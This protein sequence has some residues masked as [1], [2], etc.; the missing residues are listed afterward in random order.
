MP[1]EGPGF[2]QLEDDLSDDHGARDLIEKNTTGTQCRRVP[3]EVR[4]RVRRY[5]T[6]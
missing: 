6:R 4:K 5:A 2:Q 3:E 1:Q